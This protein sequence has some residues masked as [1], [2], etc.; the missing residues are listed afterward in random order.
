MPVNSSIPRYCNRPILGHSL[1]YVWYVLTSSPPNRSSS[2]TIPRRMFAYSYPVWE[3]KMILLAQ[4]WI[5]SC[6]M[7]PVAI[8]W[9]LLIFQCRHSHKN[10]HSYKHV[11]S[12]HFLRFC[13]LLTVSI[14]INSTNLLRL[15]Y[16]NE[17]DL[18]L[19]FT[20]LNK[21]LCENGTSVKMD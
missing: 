5:I 13:S 7:A 17:V 15:H 2:G 6:Q 16:Q 3:A 9:P 19:F 10:R 14:C 4:T 18:M 21:E 20:E 8:S 11:L 12:S 1:A